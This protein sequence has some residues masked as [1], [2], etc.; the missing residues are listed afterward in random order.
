MENDVALKLLNERSLHFNL[1]YFNMYCISSA[2]S[3]ATQ[4]HCLQKIIQT[5]VIDN[6]LERSNTLNTDDLEVQ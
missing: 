2:L 1:F 6:N 3:Q 4:S 5:V